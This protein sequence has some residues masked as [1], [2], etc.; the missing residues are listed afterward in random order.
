MVIDFR[1]LPGW[2]ADSSSA[3]RVSPLQPV[4]LP[5]QGNSLEGS[6]QMLVSSSKQS[7]FR[8]TVLNGG[9]C[10]VWMDWNIGF[11]F[12]SEDRAFT[13]GSSWFLLMICSA[14]CVLPVSTN[15]VQVHCR[16]PETRKE[17]AQIQNRKFTAKLIQP[18]MRANASWCPCRGY[19][20]YK[21]DIQNLYLLL[22]MWPCLIP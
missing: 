17:A 21:P 12:T 16:Q 15:T 6:K 14:N 22:S 2:V 5:Q 9:G 8:W 18:R 10:T 1:L 20:I 13:E 4:L 11:F 3:S 7:H 19:E